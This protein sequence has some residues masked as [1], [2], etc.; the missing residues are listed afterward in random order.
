ML[1]KSAHAL[2][3]ERELT[4][5]HDEEFHEVVVD[6]GWGRRLKDEDIFISD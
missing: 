5:N 6:G 4:R 3:S 2:R 1:R